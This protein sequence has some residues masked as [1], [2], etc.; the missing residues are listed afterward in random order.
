MG[1][2]AAGAFAIVLAAGCAG[3]RRAPVHSEA[4]ERS[5]RLLAKLDQLEADLHAQTAELLISG[6]LEDRHGT[7]TQLACRVTDDHIQEIHRL[8]AAQERKQLERAGRRKT[9]AMARTRPQRLAAQGRA[10][11]SVATN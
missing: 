1:R 3:E 10:K 11:T 2:V 9:V 5:A 4:L 6:E 8:A 7:A